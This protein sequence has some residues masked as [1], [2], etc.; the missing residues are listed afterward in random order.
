L[1]RASFAASTAAKY[2]SRADHASDS[3]SLRN[4]SRVDFALA[5]A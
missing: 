3:P 1:A 2:S 4:A 5:F